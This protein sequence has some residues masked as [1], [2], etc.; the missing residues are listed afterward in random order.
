M[1]VAIV[2]KYFLAVLDLHVAWEPLRLDPD[3]SKKLFQRFRTVYESE[4]GMPAGL[5]CVQQLHIELWPA[6]NRTVGSDSEQ[7]K[8]EDSRE[9]DPLKRM[10]LPP[11]DDVMFCLDLR[12]NVLNSKR[13]LPSLSSLTVA[14]IDA[15]Y[16]DD[17]VLVFLQCRSGMLIDWGSVQLVYQPESSSFQLQ[18]VK[19][20]G[21]PTLDLTVA[22]QKNKTRALAA[23]HNL[24][25]HNLGMQ[26]NDEDDDL[27]ILEAEALFLEEHPE[28]FK[29]SRL[30]F[31]NLRS[32]DKYL[33]RTKEIRKA[34]GKVLARHSASSG[35]SRG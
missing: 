27:R 34:Y 19:D 7:E 8:S 2:K 13:G 20:A 15:D 14:G 12:M 21:L 24:A 23:Q 32:P 3:E 16:L 18:A 17:F 1:R 22:L 6:D 11:L 10:E 35:G 33:A 9:S 5:F 29:S 30:F 28:A 4:T 26:L 25:Q 31:R